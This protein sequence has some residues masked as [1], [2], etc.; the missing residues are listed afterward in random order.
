MTKQALDEVA[1]LM[2]E[3][4]LGMVTET[5]SESR[6]ME[7]IDI[8]LGQGL[9]GKVLA[10]LIKEVIESAGYGP[11]DPTTPEPIHRVS[12]IQGNNQYANN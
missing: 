2:S 11:R 1:G 4:L 3:Y 7:I 8:L 10:N 9:N 6:R 12:G 5:I